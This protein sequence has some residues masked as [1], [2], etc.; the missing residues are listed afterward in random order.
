M[1]ALIFT[2]LV[3]MSSSAPMAQELIEFNDQSVSRLTRAE[4]TAEATRAAG[5][6]ETLTQGEI[7]LFSDPAFASGR[8]RSDVSADGR[9]ASQTHA[10]GTVYDASYEN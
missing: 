9:Q 8:S 2:A 5:A 3:A 7:T 4:V 10:R 6:G 1:R